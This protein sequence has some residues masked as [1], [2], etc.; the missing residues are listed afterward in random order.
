MQIWIYL[1]IQLNT[2]VILSIWGLNLFNSRK[3]LVIM[4]AS[5]LGHFL[6][7]IL[8][9]LLDIYWSFWTPYFLTII[10]LFYISVLFSENYYQK[11][12]LKLLLSFKFS[13]SLL[14]YCYYYCSLALPR[15]LNFLFFFFPFIFPVVCDQSIDLQH[16]LYWKNSPNQLVSNL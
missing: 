16:H 4:W 15:L 2:Q 1:Y 6:Y 12:S 8:E 10:S 9:L 7:F 5:L 13:M 14:F 3:L 11:Y